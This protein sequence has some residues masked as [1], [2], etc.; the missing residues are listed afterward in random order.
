MSSC[1]WVQ[2]HGLG[3]AER[4]GR[5]GLVLAGLAL[6]ACGSSE[7]NVADSGGATVDSGDA[8]SESGGALEDVAIDSTQAMSEEAD[9]QSEAETG[10]DAALG[11]DGSSATPDASI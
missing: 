7:P 9:R 4:I 3:L 6:G 8:T 2:A 1:V 11:S 10:Q 5:A